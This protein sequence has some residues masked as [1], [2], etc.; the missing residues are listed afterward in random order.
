MSYKRFNR[1]EVFEMKDTSLVLDMITSIG[2][3]YGKHAEVTNML[4]GLFD[5]YWYD[6]IED[7]LLDTDLPTWMIADLGAILDKVQKAIDAEGESIT[8]V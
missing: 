1:H 2:D 5:G 6:T 7:L 3:K 4:Y 8:L